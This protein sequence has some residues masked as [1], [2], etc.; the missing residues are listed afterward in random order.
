MAKHQR[1]FLKQYHFLFRY[2]SYWG[3]RKIKSPFYMY[4]ITHRLYF[5]PGFSWNIFQVCLQS[6][7]LNCYFNNLT[8]CRR[9][10][11]S[12]WRLECLRPHH[13]VLLLYGVSNGSGISKIHLVEKVSNQDANHRLCHNFELS[14]CSHIHGLQV[15]FSINKFSFCQC[16]DFHLFVQRLLQQ[17]LS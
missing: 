14:N 16:C 12:I 1:N 7:K 4:I 9:T 3:R 17:S 5:A 10:R 8:I 13:H 15:Q 6:H 2:S 11:N